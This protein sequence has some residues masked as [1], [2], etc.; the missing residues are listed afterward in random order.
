MNDYLKYGQLLQINES[1]IYLQLDPAGI[2][3][4]TKE[5]PVKIYESTMDMI[6]EQVRLVFVKAPYQI[7]T[8]EAE[9]V[10][11]DHVAKPSTSSRDASLS[12]ACKQFF[13]KKKQIQLK[14][15][16]VQVISH[17]TTQR[18]AIAMLH[19]RIQFLQQYL[20]DVKD[21]KIP[22]DHDVVRQISSV[23]RRSPLMNSSAFDEQFTVASS[24]ATDKRVK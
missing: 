21:G 10:A 4:G 19:A 18:N 16:C 5:F 17:L 1:A 3:G 14:T 24:I 8:N 2:A 22:L 12:N 9:R 20:Q 7:E 15:N 13:L 6:D 23:C 11:V